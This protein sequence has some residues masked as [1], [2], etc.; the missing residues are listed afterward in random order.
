VSYRVPSQLRSLHV[1]AVLS[2]L[3][4]T[5]FEPTPGDSWLLLGQCLQAWIWICSSR[6]AQTCLHLILQHLWICPWIG[7]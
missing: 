2:E 6:S 3:R 4:Y 7:F 1:L 5:F